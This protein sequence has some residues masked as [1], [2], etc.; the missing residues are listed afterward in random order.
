MNFFEHQD[1][2][3]RKT[4]HLVVL[5]VLAVVFLIALTQLLVVGVMAWLN[6]V[7][8]QEWQ[9]ALD[10]FS[11]PT[12]LKVAAGIGLV[13]MLASGYKFLQLSSGGKVVAEAMGG[14]LVNIN[15]DD[16]DERKLLNV[17]Q[18]MAIASG[19]PVPPVYLIDEAGI[20]AFAAGYKPADAV[21][22]VTRGCVQ[23]LERDELQGVIAHEFSHI[24]NGDMRLNIRLIGVLHGILVIG[25]VG[26]FILRSV[27][28]TGYR[29]RSSKNNS[30]L[31]F[32][33][34]G[35]GLMVIGYAGTFFGNWI[36]AA[37]SRQR[38][39]LADSSAVQFTR[40]PAGISGALKKIGGFSS[41]SAI[42]HPEAQEISHLFF[43]QAVKPFLSS[44]M[45]THPPL[46]ERIKRIDPS[47]NG[48]F[49]NASHGAASD[50]Y[51]QSESVV[52]FAGA[53]SRTSSDTVSGFAASSSAFAASAAKAELLDSIGG[54]D[55]KHVDYARKLLATLPDEVL[56]AASE[57]YGARALVYCLL[58]D[59]DESIR[60]KQWQLLKQNANSVV[61][62]F[63]R[64]LCM[65]FE[66]SPEYRLPLLELSLP[67]LK[68]LTADQ[69][70]RFRKNVVTLMQAD[71]RIDLHE[72]ALYRVLL[73]HL[74]PPK[75]KLA[76]LGAI[77]SLKLVGKAC[78]LLLSAMAQAGA[79]S[80]ESAHQAFSEAAQT[81]GLQRLQ[82]VRRDEYALADLSRA[83]QLLCR[84]Q[85]LQKPRLLKALCACVTHDGQIKPVEIE[86]IRAVALNL[87]CPMPPLVLQ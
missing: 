50:V 18:E 32:L 42:E 61:F 67:A 68:Q 76:E 54:T 5:F 77:R 70:E 49:E 84:L 35:A 79:D 14:R 62:S 36:K 56:E 23:Q 52:G 17:V 46:Q 47:W 86:L 19:T 71:A 38:E 43:G 13:V 20:N 75:S 27:S 64:Q 34:L 2:A 57:P 41:G 72:W 4:G 26:Y 58:L 55:D 7:P 29:S 78:G 3:R 69:Y 6:G 1:N 74:Q 82:F 21:I 31:P 22:G 63:T 15:S 45:A 44:L 53:A 40:N 16:A 33:A 10:Y 87:D 85:P 51:Q 81:L 24:F 60:E 37:V 8:L 73:Y 65:S 25:M 48:R 80:D 12:L 11:W 83:L 9:L 59:S 30:A 39:F 28:R 66:M